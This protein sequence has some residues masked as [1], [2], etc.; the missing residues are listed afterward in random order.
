MKLANSEAEVYMQT[1]HA[2]IT[3]YTSSSAGSLNFTIQYHLFIHSLNYC[4]VNT[5]YVLDIMIQQEVRYKEDPP[6]SQ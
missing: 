5:S 1:C 6:F 3:F 2:P 4:L